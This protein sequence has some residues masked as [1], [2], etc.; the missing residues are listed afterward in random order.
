MRFN[1]LNLSEGDFN[2]PA[3]PNRLWSLLTT[4]WALLTLLILV[5]LDLALATGGFNAA[6]DPALLQTKPQ[7]AQWLEAQPG[8]WRITSFNP[9]GDKP[10]NANAGWFYHLQDVRGYDSIIARQ[11]T[12]YMGA[13]EPQNELPFNRVQPIANWESLNSPLLDIL[14][15]KYII[16]AET[17]ELPKL[18]LAWEGEGLRVYENLAVVP[19][20]ITLPTT[21]TR[22]TLDPLAELKANDPR[23]Y[24][25]ISEADWPHHQSHR[26]TTRRFCGS[27][28]YSVQQC[29]GDGGYD[30]RRGIVAGVA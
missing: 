8:L 26:R 1:A 6:A 9:H 15:V 20:A 12:D 28:S 29:S 7:L 18:Q 13:I 22:V 14:G 21:A 5:A 16:T 25:I 19:R 11:Y 23:Q 3:L 10:F 4:H 17:I 24:V 30:G 2:P 27:N